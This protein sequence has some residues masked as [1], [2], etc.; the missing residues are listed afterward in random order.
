MH[1][2][3]PALDKLTEHLA[4]VVQADHDFGVGQ[5]SHSWRRVPAEGR[6]SD[7]LCRFGVDQRIPARSF[8]SPTHPPARIADMRRKRARQFDMCM[9]AVII[10][11]D[12]YGS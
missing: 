8:Q 5:H 9:L 2:M 10:A 12:P 4:L 3:A 6:Q 7:L 11:S 1:C